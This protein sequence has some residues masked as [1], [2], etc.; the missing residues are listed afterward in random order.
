MVNSVEARRPLLAACL[1]RAVAV[2]QNG[3]SVLDQLPAWQ[4]SIDVRIAHQDFEAA[5]DVGLQVLALL[6][7]HLPSCPGPEQIGAAIH[8]TVEALAKVG[9]EGMAAL[10]KADEPN[11][12]AGARVL[13]R[14]SSAAYFG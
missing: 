7:V 14:I 12:I 3:A 2:R 9:P 1:S 11:V 5:V 13:T 6:G 4:V 8:R 10:D